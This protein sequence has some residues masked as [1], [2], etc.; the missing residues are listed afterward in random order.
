MKILFAGTPD[1]AVLPLK[2]IIENGFNVVGVV[3]QADKPQGRKG[4]LTAPPV[5]VFAREKG[6]PVFQ[7]AKIKDEINTLKSF[8]ADIMITC[9][10]GQILTQG[11]LDC[12]P[13]GV[14]N[15]HAGLL[16]AYRGASPIQ[17]CIISGETETGVSIM[18]TEL[19]L[20]CGD[21]LC[22]EK[23]EI[24]PDE[25]YGQLSDRLSIIGAD[26]IVKA[27]K[28]L[29]TGDYT[30]VKQA[31]TGVNVVRKI[32][33]EQG[34]IDFTKTAREIVDLVRGMNPAPVAYTQVNDL[35]INVYLAEKAVLTDEEKAA[36]TQAVCGEV[37]SD[38]VKRGLIV[39]CGDGAVK[40]LQVQAAGGKI[41]SGNDFLN[42][43]KAQ[44]GQV[45]VC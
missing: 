39:K 3:T 40:L 4:V 16:P 30:L 33:K 11:V 27:L 12:F 13:K 7:P 15:I 32:G 44:K 2:N 18:Q 1:F 42:G 17:S 5:K 36:W 45:F 43:R 22:V 20:D 6:I 10:Y 21:I 26:L 35:K 19:G 23:T 38:K 28:L 25:T 14:W 24:S 31:E 34:K 9:A 8:G 29:E 37:L 41:M